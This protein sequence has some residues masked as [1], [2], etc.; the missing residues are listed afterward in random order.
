MYTL[1]LASAE[2]NIIWPCVLLGLWS[3]N[4]LTWLDVVSVENGDVSSAKKKKKKKRETLDTS[5]DADGRC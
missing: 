4:I 5:Q 1:I 2:K 3:E